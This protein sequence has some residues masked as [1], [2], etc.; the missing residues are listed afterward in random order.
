MA[1]TLCYLPGEKIKDPTLWTSLRGW[2][3]T[4]N[5]SAEKIRWTPDFLKSDG[6]DRDELAGAL[7]LL[8]GGQ[9]QKVVYFEPRP[10]AAKDLDWLAF[11]CSCIQLGIAVEDAEGQPLLTEEKASVL[12]DLFMKASK[13]PAAPARRSSRV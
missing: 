8:R 5:L 10:R 11:A 2:Q 3:K 9:I 7:A 12:Q 1:Q 6:I 4:Q 13:K